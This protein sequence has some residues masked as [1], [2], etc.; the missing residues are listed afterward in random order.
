MTMYASSNSLK[1]N[2]LKPFRNIYKRKKTMRD[3]EMRWV[4]PQPVAKASQPKNGDVFANCVIRGHQGQLQANVTSEECKHLQL[5][6]LFPCDMLP[7]HMSGWTHAILTPRFLSQSH[8][9]LGNS[10]ASLWRKYLLRLWALGSGFLFFLKDD[11]YLF[12]L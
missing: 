2:T 12:L 1:L 8:G 11:W 7:C 9:I 4:L 6:K 10:V 5:T 3:D